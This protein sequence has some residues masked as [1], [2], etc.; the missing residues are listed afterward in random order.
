MMMSFPRRLGAGLIGLALAAAPIAD[1]Q[2]NP[3][4]LKYRTGQT[5][6]PIFEGWSR[7]A[8]GGFTMHFG[9]FNRNFVEQ[10]HVPVGPDNHF[11]DPGLPDAGQPTFF[12]PRANRRVFSID[13]PSDFGDRRL[14]WNLTTQG[15]TL[16]AIGWL[17]PTWETAARSAG[18]RRLSPEA[19]RNTAPE[20]G[21]DVPAAV[22]LQAGATLVA[23]VT[24]DGLPV[25][26][27]LD[28][29]RP[30]RGSND[31]PTLQRGPD[32][33]EP[34]HNVPSVPNRRGSGVQ[35]PRVRGLRVSWIVWR[36]PAGVSFEPAATVAVEDGQASVTAAFT[37]PGDYVL[38]ATA[39][40]NLLTTEHDV[41][42]SVR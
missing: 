13:V 24:D 42:V 14:V 1:A 23:R 36:G 16:R 29:N 11:D 25:V 8:D 40:D 19:A 2:P 22:T 26:R 27:E 12:Y 39:N 9:Y 41:A 28:P 21:V 15:E 32:D 17:E 31:P 37:V 30:R 34:P 35:Q 4:N 7:K 6:Q 10:V 20:I 3:Y 5:V 33:I 38:R 18:G